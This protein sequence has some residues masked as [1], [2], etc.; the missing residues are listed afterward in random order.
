MIDSR[1]FV[2]FFKSKTGQVAAFGL[3]FFIGATLLTGV[4]YWPRSKPKCAA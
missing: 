2:S 1:K 3:L 4:L